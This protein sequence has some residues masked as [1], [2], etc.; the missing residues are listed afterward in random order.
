MPWSLWIPFIWVTINATRPLARWLSSGTDAAAFSDDVSGGSFYDR[1]TYVLLMVCGILALFRRPINWRPIIHNCHW[2]II[3]FGYYLIST[4][5]SEDIFVAFKRWIKAVG[6]IIMILILLTEADPVEALR[7]V[8]LRCYYLIVPLSVVSIKYYKEIGRYYGKWEWETHYCGLALNKNS[9]G[10]LAML[11]GLFLLWHMVDMRPKRDAKP[12]LLRH[13]PDLVVLGMCLWLLYLSKSSTS[14]VCLAVGAAIFFGGR[15]TMFKANLRSLGWCLLLFGG[16]MLMFTV[17]SDFRGIIAGM[18]G[19]NATLTDRTLIWDMLL[20][21]GS[22]PIIGEGFE[23]FWL[24]SKGDNVTD[25]FHVIYAHN[26][27]LDAYLDTGLLGVLLFVVMLYVAGRNAFSHY[28]GGSRLGCVFLSLFWS[29][30]LF[31]YTE[32]AFGKSNVFGLIIL[33]IVVYG[34]FS[35]ASQTAEEGLESAAPLWPQDQGV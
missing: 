10:L 33:L 19:R 5:W 12:L 8:F 15:L 4:V 26:G 34:P 29:C 2:L 3:L 13:G 14:T 11:G 25:E 7:A 30:L 20:K 27:Y 24:T 1:Y 16:F 17:S 22:N 31:N 35:S 21:S 32:I 28:K 9:L 18:V 23:S 6:D